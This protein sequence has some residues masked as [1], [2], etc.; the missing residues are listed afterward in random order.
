MKCTYEKI[1]KNTSKNARFVNEQ[2][3][4]IIV[5]MTNF[6]NCRFQSN[7]EKKSQW[8]WS[9]IFFR[10]NDVKKNYDFIIMIIDR[11]IKI[12]IYISIMKTNEMCHLLFD[13]IFLKY[14]S[15]KNII[16]NCKF[17]FINNFWSILCYHAKI[18]RKFNIVFHLQTNEQTKK[19][20]QIF[21]HYLKY[22]CNHE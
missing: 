15:S 4:I 12:T 17:L 19:Q 20:N 9:R 21:E 16:L 7:R 6:S 3:F 5:F 22:F 8:I 2:K 14:D 13:D 1:S 11:Y 10:T 18:K